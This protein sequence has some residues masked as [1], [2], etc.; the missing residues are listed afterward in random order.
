M[1]RHKTGIFLEFLLRCSSM[2]ESKKFVSPTESAQTQ[3]NPTDSKPIVMSPLKTKSK[4]RRRRIVIPLIIVIVLGLILLPVI[5]TASMGSKIKAQALVFQSHATQ[6]ANALKAQDLP[7]AKTE[8]EASNQSLDTLI[9]TYSKI[10]FL[11]YS[12]VRA[13]YQDGTHLLTAADLGVDAG[14]ALIAGLEPHA[15]ILGLK[16]AGTFTGG[17]AEDRLVNLVGSLKELTPTFETVQ[18]KLD[19]ITQEIEAISP[20]RYPFKVNGQPASEMIVAA[21]AKLHDADNLV[22]SIYP[23]IQVLPDI[24]GADE[25]KTYLILFQNDAELRPTGGFLTAYAIVNVKSGKVTPVKSD[26]MYDLDAKFTQKISPPEVVRKNL[27][28]NRLNLRDMNLDP[29]FKNSMTSFMQYYNELPGEPKVDGVIA[30]DTKVLTDLL[31]VLGDIEVPGYGKFSAKIDERCNCPQVIYEL[32]DIIGR[33]TPYLRSERKAILGPMMQTLLFKAYGSGNEQWPALFNTIFNN[34]NEKHVLFYFP[35]ERKQ[36]AFETNNYAG[37]LK[38]VNG[39]DYLHI[40]DANFGGA[41]S[42]LFITQDVNQDIKVNGDQATKVV[43]I[44]YKNPSPGSNCNLEAGQLCLNGMLG[45][46]QRVYVPLGSKL[47]DAK[48][49]VPGSVKESDADDKHVIEGFFKLAPESQATI[50]LT[51][52]VPQKAGSPYIVQIQKQPGTKTP[53]HVV[54][55]DGVQQILDLTTDK[56]LT[57]NSE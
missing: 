15:D 57:F 19:A 13:Y 49:Y 27:L 44:T 24:M 37:R 10:K 7:T 36:T 2:S 1:V 33:P 47:I 32:E 53:H 29:D 56:T 45:N 20:E 8:L 34:L 18:V 22:T 40:N 39:V 4:K 30:I 42:N 38:P 3:N 17:T 23:I 50:T 54:S 11:R 12:P 51:Y 48:G 41:K 9:S 46:W 55:V 21:K 5:Y 28:V 31:T 16:G 14:L 6:A 43:T 26:D 52:S 35:D 25:E